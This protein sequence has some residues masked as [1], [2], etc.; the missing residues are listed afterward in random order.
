MWPSLNFGRRYLDNFHQVKRRSEICSRFPTGSA[1]QQNL[2]T[3][4]PGSDQRNRRLFKSQ[5]ALPV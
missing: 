3:N 5:I 1:G 2:G 4:P